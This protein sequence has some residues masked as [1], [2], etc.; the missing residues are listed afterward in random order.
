MLNSNISL[1][2]VNYLDSRVQEGFTI[3]TAIDMF[4]EELEAD[5]RST[6]S[7]IEKATREQVKIYGAER[8]EKI[9]MAL[10]VIEYI[11]EEEV[12]LFEFK[13]LLRQEIEWQAEEDILNVEAAKDVI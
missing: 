1:E 3:E 10:D 11:V 2:V 8:L 7:K 12:D 6:T 5:F 13:Q 4:R 9:D